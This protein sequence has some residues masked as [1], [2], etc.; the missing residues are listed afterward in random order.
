MNDTI[1]S[2]LSYEYT[3]RRRAL[4]ALNNLDNA[5]PKHSQLLQQVDVLVSSKDK[6]IVSIT[7]TSR[8]TAMDVAKASG[9][10]SQHILKHLFIQA[11]VSHQLF[12][13]PVL[14]LQDLS[15]PNFRYSHAGKFPLPSIEGLLD[16]AHIAAD[17][18][19]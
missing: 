6:V 1:S 10:F 4:E 5:F 11:Q 16:C 13:L 3:S 8:A 2:Q 9:L 7:L 18:R 19:D 15:P 17:L 12:Q 14:L